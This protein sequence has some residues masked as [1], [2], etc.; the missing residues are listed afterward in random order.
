MSDL[1]L[2]LLRERIEIHVGL[3]TEEGDV[4][5][6]GVACVGETG[7]LAR[8]NETCVKLWLMPSSRLSRFYMQSQRGKHEHNQAHSSIFFI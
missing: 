1:N 7:S 5:R 4:Q 3:T 8:K 2:P 6:A